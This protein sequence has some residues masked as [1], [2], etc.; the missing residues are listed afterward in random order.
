MFGGNAEITSTMRKVRMNNRE[1]DSHICK[2][3]TIDNDFYNT[4]LNSY[5][6]FSDPKDFNDP[7]DLNI[8]LILPDY[9]RDDISKLVEMF[10]KKELLSRLV[11]KRL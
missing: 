8:N 6:W 11:M 3:F 5:L 9:N 1:F 4:I 2:Y 10:K 7:Y